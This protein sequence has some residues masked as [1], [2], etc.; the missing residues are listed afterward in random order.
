[1]TADP[2]APVRAYIAELA[3]ELLV[4]CGLPPLSR[5]R[6]T[7][8]S[9]RKAKKPKAAPTRGVVTSKKPIRRKKLRKAPRAILRPLTPAPAPAPSAPPKVLS[10]AER[11][12]L[13]KV[14]ASA[15]RPLKPISPPA[16]RAAPPP[17]SAVA[18]IAAPVAGGRVKAP[19]EREP[20]GVGRCGDCKRT[21]PLFRHKVFA[22]CRNCHPY[23]GQ[24]E[25]A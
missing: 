7:S 13:L 16:K 5:R 12:E 6:R 17:V 20:M 14:R 23:G 11:L 19:A 15:P 8:T 4:A 18:P 3:D 24:L 2:L 10:Q 1:M 9:V 21:E 22:L 25:A